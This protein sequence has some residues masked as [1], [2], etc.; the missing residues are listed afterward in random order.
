MNILTMFTAHTTRSKK[1]TIVD[2]GNKWAVVTVKALESLLGNPVPFRLFTLY[3]LARSIGSGG[4]VT[5]S[6]G[7]ILDMGEFLNNLRNLDVITSLYLVLP[8]ASVALMEPL[9]HEYGIPAINVDP[10]CAVKKCEEW[11]SH[12]LQEGP[13]RGWMDGNKRIPICK[14]LQLASELPPG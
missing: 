2:N 10:F 1:A 12:I 9:I 7:V 5:L 8:A 14:L 13:S 6:E 4:R 3:W 11:I